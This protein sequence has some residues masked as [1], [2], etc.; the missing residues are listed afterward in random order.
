MT[1]VSDLNALQAGVRE[2]W[3]SFDIGAV[4]QNAVRLRVMAN[5]TAQWHRH[6]TSDEIGRASCRERV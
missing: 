5:K 6:E 3:K 4:N 2:T 1:I